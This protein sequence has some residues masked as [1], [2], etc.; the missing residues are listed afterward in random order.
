MNARSLLILSV[1]CLGLAPPSMSSLQDMFTLNP[2][3]IN[4][5]DTQENI[6][7]AGEEGAEEEKRAGKEDKERRGKKENGKEQKERREGKKKEGKEG[8]RGSR[9]RG[10]YKEEEGK[11]EERRRRKGG[12]EKNYQMIT[13]RAANQGKA[14]PDRHQG[15]R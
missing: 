6:G 2:Y 9:S 10:E 4:E 8:E 13:E 11:E 14:N 3:L 5:T 1:S 15:A 7:A 12:R